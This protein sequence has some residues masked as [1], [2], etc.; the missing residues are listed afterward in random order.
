MKINI[1][2][3]FNSIIELK[4]MIFVSLFVHL[5]TFIS[6]ILTDLNAVFTVVFLYKLSLPFTFY[7]NSISSQINKKIY[8][9]SIFYE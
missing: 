4:T 9:Y 3:A 7:F 8:V 5:C 1:W 2:G 6:E